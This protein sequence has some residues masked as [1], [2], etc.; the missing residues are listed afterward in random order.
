MK[1]K[2]EK[3]ILIPKL[4]YELEQF[5][6]ANDDYLSVKELSHLIGKTLRYQMRDRD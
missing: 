3:L 2:Y 5:A 6:N 1:A 4:I